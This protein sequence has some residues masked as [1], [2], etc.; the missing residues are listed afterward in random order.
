MTGILLIDKPRGITSHDVVARMRRVLQER[1]IGHTGTLDPMATGL[2]VLVIGRATRLASLLSGSD[3]TYDATIRLGTATTTDDA[4]GIALGEAT[5]QLPD[6]AA[7]RRVLEAFRGTFP[8]VPPPHSAKKVDGVRAYRLARQDKPV[9]LSPV[10]VTVRELTW[11]GRDGADVAVR[12]Q[13]TA[14]F[15]VRA[16]ARDIG[17]RLG[18]GAHLAALRRLRSGSF[19][20]A[21]AWRLDEAESA[22]TATAARLIPPG[23][24]LPELA[25]AE[26]TEAGL[27]RVLHGNFVGAEH[28]VGMPPRPD[29]SPLPVRI[30]CDGRLV[31]LARWRAGALHPV[32]VL[33]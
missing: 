29:E 30:M 8:Q 23:D 31:A 25:A 32:V 2:L 12:V 22:A 18:C 21:D 9:N 4:E 5:A 24:A 13:A 1:S 26:V 20:V 7:V 14:G 19:D 33:G 27:A 17:E 3:K 11:L 6:D 16:L 28:L 15:Y 10:D